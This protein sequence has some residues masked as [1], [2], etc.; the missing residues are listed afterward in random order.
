MSHIKPAIGNAGTK[1]SGRSSHSKILQ[2]S[3]KNAAQKYETLSQPG[4]TPQLRSFSLSQ[5]V[6]SLDEKRIRSLDVSKLL[7][8]RSQRSET[9]LEKNKR[10]KVIDWDVSSAEPE[11]T[12]DRSNA[13]NSPSLVPNSMVG[14]QHP[15]ST[16]TMRSLRRES[17]AVDK[18]S[19]SRPQNSDLAPP[20]SAPASTARSLMR[21][22]T[23]RSSFGDAQ[24]EASVDVDA[25][26]D[27]LQTSVL[28]MWD[29]DRAIRQ[30]A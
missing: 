9:S 29:V 4:S 2:G 21:T 25:T 10:G 15:Q 20:A 24:R 16:K 28:S 5:I 19:D 17:S 18:I 13:R 30:G 26:I 27:D 8:Q 14:H 1:S 7:S 11:P 6:S 23:A 3:S 12:D 22:G